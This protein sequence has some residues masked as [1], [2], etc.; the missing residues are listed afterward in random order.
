MFSLNFSPAG[1]GPFKAGKAKYMPQMCTFLWGGGG[2]GVVEGG[3]G[4]RHGPTLTGKFMS[5]WAK[6]S[7]T[8]FPHF[9]TYFTQ[10]GHCYLKTMIL[11]KTFECNNF[12]LS[13]MFSFQNACPIKRK[14]VYTFIFH[15]SYRT[16]NPTIFNGR[17]W[18]WFSIRFMKWH[19]STFP[20]IHSF[21]WSDWIT[22][23]ASYQL[24]TFH[25]VSRAVYKGGGPHTF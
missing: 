20:Y 7:E 9:T 16:P 1:K 14:A 24:C 2:K 23:C 5:L 19:P 18:F 6:F 15:K 12:T 4:V 3:S 21:P 8:S 17:L 25:L 13:S 22:T 11:F 10:I